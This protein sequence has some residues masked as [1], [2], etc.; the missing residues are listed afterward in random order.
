MKFDDCNLNEIKAQLK[1]QPPEKWEESSALLLK[2]SRTA[3]RK[4]GEALLGKIQKRQRE[5]IRL[6]TMLENEKKL[7]G[8]FHVI[9][10]V[11]EAGRGPLAGPVVA[12]AVILPA[13]FMPEGL[14][15]SKKVSE[16]KREQLYLEIIEN[17]LAWGVGIVGPERIDAI[18]ILEATR[19]AMQQ[20]IQQLKTQPDFVLLDAVEIKA[21]A[22]PH[23]GIIKGDEKCLS[24]AAASIIAKVTRDRLMTGLGKKLPNYGFQIHK[25][26]GTA[27]HYEALR[28]YGIT[29]HHRRSFLKGWR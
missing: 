20:A 28:Q 1:E 9:C 23:K 25:G 15:D 26:Y 29:E 10:G 3:V 16:A 21:L 27:M 19:E 4:L 7:A 18:N 12:G 5:Q 24:I 2:D 22:I 17:A 11:D 8:D 14:N 13:G 6:R